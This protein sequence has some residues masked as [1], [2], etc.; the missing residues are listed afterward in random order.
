MS[1][2]LFSI[3]SISEAL[4]TVTPWLNSNI[5]S[6]SELIKYFEQRK[7]DWFALPDWEDLGD[8]DIYERIA[9]NIVPNGKIY[10]ICESS[11]KDNSG[12]YLM[13]ATDIKTFI[14]NHLCHF[15][16]CLF[17]GDVLIFG[18]EQH[19]IWLFHHEGLYGRF[20]E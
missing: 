3:V 11:Y 20:Y 5:N 7:K 1:K 8:L 2:S 9:N 18:A 6:A 15:K 13:N 17:N 12:S 16:E 14:N 4:K 10:I 19:L